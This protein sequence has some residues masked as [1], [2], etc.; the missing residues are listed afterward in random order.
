MDRQ[1]FLD[2]VYRIAFD[3]EKENRGCAQSVLAAL[4][5]AFEMRNDEVFKAA[6]GLSGGVGLSTHGS[7]GA[8][9]GGAMAI[10]MLFGRER[11][12]FKDPDRVRWVAYRLGKQ[13]SDRF[14]R[15]YGSVICSQI[16]SSYLGRNYDLLDSTDYV[17]FDKV[18]Y[19][20]NKCPHLAG[21]A[22]VMAAEIILNELDRSDTRR[23][24][25]V[26]SGP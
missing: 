7:C 3:Y 4:Q 18:A 8:L 11:R 14:E 25:R 9:C 6:S 19:Q 10:G 17:D 16:Q 21:T 1:D 2:R 12:N 20:Q 26:A 5:D 15:E 22:A 23:Q 13:L 24:V